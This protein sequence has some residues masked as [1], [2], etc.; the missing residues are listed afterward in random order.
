M[1]KLS[2]FSFVTQER[3]QWVLTEKGKQAARKVQ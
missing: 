3:D 1:K 2:G